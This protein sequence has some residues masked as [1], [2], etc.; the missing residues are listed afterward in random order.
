VDPGRT[1][2]RACGD[3]SFPCEILGGAESARKATSHH[4]AKV[5][6]EQCIEQK[7]RDAPGS[8]GGGRCWRG[9]DCGHSSFAGARRIRGQQ[10]RARRR[11]LRALQLCGR[12]R[13]AHQLCGG[14]A[15]SGTAG[16]RRAA[17]TT[18]ARR[19]WG[20]RARGRRRGLRRRGVTSAGNCGRGRTEEMCMPTLRT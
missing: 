3:C 2:S 9:R 17:G 12:I 18:G 1:R 20:Q 5:E 13:R 7:V 15:V 4:G 14:A 19:I 16:A 11:G 8:V 10:G 6:G